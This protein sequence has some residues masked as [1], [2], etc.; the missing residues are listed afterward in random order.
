[1]PGGATAALTD[2]TFLSDTV[3]GEMSLGATTLLTPMLGALVLVTYAAVASAA[4]IVAPLRRD[5]V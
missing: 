5:L 3:S 1:M 4:A 2:F